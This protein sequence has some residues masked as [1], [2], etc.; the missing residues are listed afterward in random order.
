MLYYLKTANKLRKTKPNFSH[1]DLGI[2]ILHVTVGF[3]LCI[4]KIGSASLSMLEFSSKWRKSQIR[5]FLRCVSSQ[6][7]IPQIFMNNPQICKFVENTA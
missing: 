5:K 6:I 3:F 2:V 4:A 1:G 7:A